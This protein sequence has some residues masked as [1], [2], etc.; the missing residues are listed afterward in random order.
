MST[1]MDDLGAG[2]AV[3]TESTTVLAMGSSPSLMTTSLKS[4]TARK[5]ME[6]LDAELMG[7]YPDHPYPPPFGD[8]EAAGVG[9]V[10]IA[11][12][13]RRAVGC[14]A[15]RRLDQATAELLRMYVLPNARG[16]GIGK[17]L[18]ASLEAEAAD[19]GAAR[20]VLEA[21]DRQDDA[22]GLYESSG[23]ARIE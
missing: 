7:L 6:N 22:I 4:P 13:D 8:D 9:S 15:V 14:G 20:V 3:A 16:K 12:S 11:Y 23:Y 19:M 5:L 21:G 18:L 10:L 17:L 1:L 2:W